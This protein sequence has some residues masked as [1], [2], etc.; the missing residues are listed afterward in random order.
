MGLEGV[1]LV[2]STKKGFFF[3]AKSSESLCILVSDPSC[4]PQA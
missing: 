1:S 4:T 2:Y 3:K